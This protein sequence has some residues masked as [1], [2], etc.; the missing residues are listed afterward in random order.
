MLKRITYQLSNVYKETR[1]MNLKELKTNWDE[2]G[3][4]DPLWAILTEPTKKNNNW[5]PDEFFKTGEEEI[6]SILN[7]TESLGISSSRK[8]AF[9]FGCGV[10]RLTQALCPYFDECYGVDI[11]PS[12]I[13]S[14]NKY[15]RYGNKCNYYVNDSDNLSLFEDN[16]FDFIYSKIVLQHIKPEYSRNYI[17]EF[18][19]VLAPGG[20]L[21]FQAPSE[22][23]PVETLEALENDAYKAEIT[24]SEPLLNVK[25]GSK[26]TIR[27]KIKNLSNVTW[28][29]FADS[30]GKYN[31][32]LGNHWLNEAG[33]MLVSDDG[34]EPLPKTLEPMEEVEVSL[35]VT[36][37]DHS[38]TYI[39][40]L[41]MV[42]EQIAWFKDK[43]SSTLRIPVKVE[44]I[45]QS[46]GIGRR[47]LNL[48]HKLVAIKEIKANSP[49]FVP[50]MEMYGIPK[51]IVLKL[52]DDSGGKVLDVQQDFS[53][54][55]AWLSFLYCVTK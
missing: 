25:A 42:H 33:R 4:Q 39:L 41:D 8:R 6:K 44:G 19:R 51:E 29:S 37:P 50:R 35:T 28:P 34:R 12:M 38:S 5:K 10:G 31:I 24:L 15:N 22:L 55:Q 26:I 36:V 14:A 45:S 21:V 40:E 17:K 18:L 30:S 20:L 7:Y 53:T 16:Y 3:K 47:I 1:G 52:I 32:N 11:A 48:Y 54:G 27:V 49:F 43:G 46:Q 2:F 9:D 23:A 13:E